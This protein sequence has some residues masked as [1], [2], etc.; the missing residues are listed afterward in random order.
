MVDT[1]RGLFV[2]IIISLL[3]YLDCYPSDVCNPLQQHAAEDER[4]EHQD[5]LPSK[6]KRVIKC[7]LGLGIHPMS[8]GNSIM[9][10]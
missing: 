5:Q 8:K 3:G 7:N 10:A 4:L 6:V 1:P 2:R 9:G